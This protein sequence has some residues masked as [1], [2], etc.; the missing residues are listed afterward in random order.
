MARQFFLLAILF[1]C[2]SAHAQTATNIVDISACPKKTISLSIHVINDTADQPKATQ[3]Q[4]QLS[5]D[6]LNQ[7]FSAMCVQF[8]ICK[9]DTVKENLYFLKTTEEYLTEMTTKYNVP[10][11]IN[12]YYTGTVTALW[13]SLDGSNTLTTSAN[14]KIRMAN[15]LFKDFML[16]NYGSMM[17]IPHAMGHYFGL[18]DTFDNP[19]GIAELAN[20]SNCQSAGD[21]ICDTEADPAIYTAIVNCSLTN[22]TTDANGEYYTPPICNLMSFYAGTCIKTFTTE[23]FNRMLKA[24]YTKRNYL[25]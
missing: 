22:P 16:I 14:D 19:S 2:V 4:I 24:F 7:K 10:N 13:G 11:T 20:G 9:F 17:E 5:I 15:P 3:G 1:C 23:Q 18:Y 25:W 21:S 8:S 12:V 6:L